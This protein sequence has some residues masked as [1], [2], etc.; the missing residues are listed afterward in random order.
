MTGLAEWD[1]M[2][3]GSGPGDDAAR[4]SGEKG[5]VVVVV[6]AHP[7]AEEHD[8]PL[9]YALIKAIGARGGRA[10]VCTDL[11]YLNDADL[12]RRATLSLGGPGV[13]ALSASLIGT[14]PHVLTVHD[15][16]AVQFDPEWTDALAC[17]WGVDTRGTSTATA[18][19]IE[20]YLSG[21][22]RAAATR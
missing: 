4:E 5:R 16:Y 10:G 19:F 6:G 7:R 3:H 11:W 15:R 22:L 17:V 20:R 2:A 21:F 13:N 1:E 8:R 14:L 18:M 12:R 9:A